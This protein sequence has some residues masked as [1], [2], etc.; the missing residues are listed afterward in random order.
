LATIDLA[1]ARCFPSL[2]IPETGWKLMRL[3]IRNG[4]KTP[5][6]RGAAFSLIEAMV[7]MAVLGVMVAGLFGGM[8]WGTTSLRI[9]REDLRASQILLEKMEVIRLLTWDQITA[10][11]VLPANFTSSYSTAGTSNATAVGP[12]YSGTITMAPPKGS[13]MGASYTNDM[14]VVSVKVAWTNMG[15][16]H[17][18]K[19]NT[20]VSRYG[21]QNYLINN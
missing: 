10:S 15:Q 4:P 17:F 2:A 16:A 6:G 1:R 21:I 12:I 13:T 8:S 14:R 18:R 11:N 5:N 7:G 9:S 3:T 19:V 20:Y